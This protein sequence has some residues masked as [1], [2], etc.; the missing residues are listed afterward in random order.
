MA[1][2]LDNKVYALLI[3]LFLGAFVFAA[4]PADASTQNRQ[5]LIIINKMNNK[6]AYI[7]SQNKMY[8]FTI[9]TG[10]TKDLTPVGEYRIV[11]KIINRP[12]YTSV[13]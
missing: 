9:S 12:Y 6:L 13:A 4:V 2:L 1:R 8:T 3:V 11:N 7:N 5:E 10:K